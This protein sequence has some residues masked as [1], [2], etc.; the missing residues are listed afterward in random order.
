MGGRGHAG[1][2]ALADEAS[3]AHMKLDLEKPATAGEGPRGQQGGLDVLAVVLDLHP[4]QVTPLLQLLPP[5]LEPMVDGD[6]EREEVYLP[7]MQD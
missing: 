3:K 6:D 5:L 4:E 2:D 7:L 1:A